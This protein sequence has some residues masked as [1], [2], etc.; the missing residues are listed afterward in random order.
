MSTRKPGRVMEYHFLR[1]KKTLFQDN[2]PRTIYDI[3]SVLLDS[4]WRH[5]NLPILHWGR[6]S[7]HR[8]PWIIK[9][10]RQF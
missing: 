8:L 9:T 1:Q 10:R 3:Q 5:D 4:G 2:I 7:R 6:L